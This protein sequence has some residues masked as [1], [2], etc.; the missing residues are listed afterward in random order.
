MSETTDFDSMCWHDNAIHGFG[1]REGDDGHGGEL[2]LDID[3][4][5]EWIKDEQS[6]NFRISPATLTF[7]EVSS[8]KISIDYESSSACVQP[9]TIQE[10]RRKP[11]RTYDDCTYF[12]WEIETNWPFD[13][14]IKFESVG[15]TQTL[16][17]DPIVFGAQ[18]LSPSQRI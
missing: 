15:F 1:I 4:I 6:F 7:H 2:D 17:K 10:I 3:Y 14:L 8:L 18:Y 16:R 9:M 13:G 11:I 5:L 12:E